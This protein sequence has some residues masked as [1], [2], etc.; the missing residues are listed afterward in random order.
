VYLVILICS[1]F[2]NA[3]SGRNDMA[4]GAN[5]KSRTAKVASTAP[6]LVDNQP[7]VL[8][9]TPG[10]NNT[11]GK[12]FSDVIA[13]ARQYLDQKYVKPVQT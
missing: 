1:Q 10:F 7:V 5:L 13:E 12:I 3:A 8:I 9:D 4:V 11:E 6:F 2:I